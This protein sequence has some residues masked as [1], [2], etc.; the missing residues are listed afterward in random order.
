LPPGP[1]C[2]PSIKT[3]DAV[4]NS[5]KTDYLFFSAKS[6]FKGY[7]NFAS[8]YQQHLV[9]ARAYQKAL[10]SMILRKKAKQIEKN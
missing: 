6:D 3:I 2:T 7:S 9:F 10:D 8:N 4:L 5:P 1:I